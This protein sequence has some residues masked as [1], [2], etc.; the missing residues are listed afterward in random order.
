ML[1]RFSKNIR[2]F[3]LAE[4]QLAQTARNAGQFQNEFSHLENAHVLGQQ[5]TYWHTKVHIMMLLWAFR[6]RQRGEALGQF[7][8]I[9]GAAT[10]TALG[11]VPSG[12]TGGSNISPFKTLPIKAEHQRIIARARSAD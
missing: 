6:Q 12:N 5:S 9:I 3:V 2:P 1:T 4:L 10:K 7:M 11:W 8:R